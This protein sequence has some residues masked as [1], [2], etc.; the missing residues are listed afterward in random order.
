MEEKKEK[1]ELSFD[2]GKVKNFFKKQKKEVKEKEEKEEKEISLDFKSIGSFFKRYKHIIVPVVLIVF[3]MFLSF[4]YRNYSSSLPITDDWAQNAV[5]NFYKDS[6]REQVNKQYPNLP[7][8][9]K[10][11]LVETQFQEYLK[12]NSATI[13]EQVRATSNN[14]KQQFK[15]DDG[16][17]YLLA[18]DPYFYYRQTKNLLE[19]G[20]VGDE[21]RDGVPWNTYMF[22]PIG[23]EIKA[24]FH[25]Y[26]ILYTYKVMHFFNR[27]ISLMGA[28]FYVPIIISMLS[29]IPAFFIA[30]KVGGNVGGFFAAFIV[31]V[32]SAF[33]NRT[34]G[35]FADTDAYNVFFPLLIAWVFLEAFEAKDLK[36]KL[37]LGTLTGLF[38]GVFSSAWDAG[39]WYIFDFILVVVIA[40]IGYYLILHRSGIKN[41]KKYLTK[42]QIKKPFLLLVTFFAS[43]ALFVTLIRGKVIYFLS[44]FLNPIEFATIKRAAHENLWPNV[45]TTVAELNPANVSQIIG[46]IGGSIFFIISLIGIILTLTSEKRRNLGIVLASVGWFVFLVMMYKT[47][48]NLYVFLGLLIIP[49]AISILYS[50]YKKYE[51]IDMKYAFFLT[52]WFLGTIYASTKGVR[53][54]LLLVPGFSVA[55]GIGIGK[56]Y[57]MVSEWGTKALNINKILV[58]SIIIV[59]LLLLLI[60][61]TKDAANSAKNEI[62][63]MNDGWYESLKGIDNNASKDAIINSWWD[64]GHWFKAIGNRAVTFD[65][66][67]Q[68]NPQAHW[69]G[70]VLLTDD[71]D[72]AIGILRMLD[73][74][75]NNAFDVLNNEIKDTVKTIDILYEILPKSKSQA[76]IILKRYV[77]DK[78]ANEIL[79]LTHCSPPEDFFI[80]SQDMVSKSGVWSHFGGWDFRRAKMWNNSKTLNQGRFVE[81]MEN[82]FNYKE[83]EAVEIYYE[84][85]SITDETEANNWISPWPG[86]AGFSSCIKEE[87]DVDNETIIKCDN[88]ISINLNKKEVSISTNQ[89][90]MNPY[91]LGYMENDKFILKKFENNTL[92]DLS[93]DLI[94]DSD[95]NYNIL[96][97]SPQLAESMFTRL[98]YYDGAG[99]KHFDMFSDIKDVTGAR[100]IVWKVDWEGK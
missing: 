65:G 50:L 47:I 35:G 37:I 13:N 26:F 89:G 11:V 79:D 98:F 51:D 40:Y 53:F 6:I 10:D 49:V 48:T 83:D 4:H 20:T 22:A 66:A 18:I 94:I 91:S 71:E 73:C 84:L 46:T 27:D 3:C 69:I 61:P 33:I 52:L 99:L 59:L 39:W 30:K 88:G 29:V 41:L 23:K 34:A 85:K 60:A 55:F 70:N 24:Y 58:R 72:V 19:T 16:R 56:I 36:K 87:D 54:I 38:I 93:V 5:Y 25:H 42:E 57:D 82:E 75:A 68:N 64:F 77:S 67:S 92:V 97:L 28:M 78:K 44:A 32:H 80:T 21:I 81:F 14:F 76:K 63:S 15:D 74:G 96:L 90:T 31:A 1:D 45:Y 95:G 43:S 62:P 100:I 8:T 86:Y 17:T 9:N 12:Q 2:F 7:D